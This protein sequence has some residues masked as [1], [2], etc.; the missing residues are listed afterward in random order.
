VRSPQ[1]VAQ[2]AVDAER[3]PTRDHGDPRVD[4][5]T[6]PVQTQEREVE[7]PDEQSRV[8]LVDLVTRDVPTRGYQPLSGSEFD[9]LSSSTDVE[10][11]LEI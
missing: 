7:G 6:G 2:V 9:V 11:E 10:L 1:L 5:P 3:D 8:N 4:E